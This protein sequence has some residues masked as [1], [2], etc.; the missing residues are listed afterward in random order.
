MRSNIYLAIHALLAIVLAIRVIRLRW[1]HRVSLGHGDQQEL[2][3]AT[4]VFGNHNEYT[5]IFLILLFALDLQSAPSVLIHGL[6]ITF[7]LG[8]ISH[9][10]GLTLGPGKTKGR[11]VGMLL[12]FASLA[13]AAT[14]LICFWPTSFRH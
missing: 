6:G 9:A 10:I 2:L 11:L 1:R 8:R 3:T 12:T 7:T 5:P 14:A 13:V 4:R